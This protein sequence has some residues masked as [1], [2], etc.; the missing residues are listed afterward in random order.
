MLQGIGITQ[1]IAIGQ[2]VRITAG[3]DAV[4]LK[5]PQ[6]E[7]LISP[8]EERAKLLA[9][10][11][12]SRR[13]IQEI[14]ANTTGGNTEII[15]TQMDYFDDPAFN[16][17]SFTLIETEGLSAIQAIE[18][19]TRELYETFQSFDDDPYMQGR[20]ADIADAGNRILNNLLGKATDITK[21]IPPDSILAAR[22]LSPSQTA[23]LDLKNVLGF[24]TEQG[25]KTCHTAIMARSM[26]IA[27]VVGCPGIMEAT[28]DGDTI[29]VDARN[30]TVLLRPDIAEREKYAA[31]QTEIESGENLLELI[32]ESRVM[33]RDNREII[34]AANI[35]NPAEAETAKQRGA[36]G[37]G[38]FRTEFLFMSRD[39]MPDEEEQYAAYRRVAEIFGEAPVIIRTLDAG[40]DKELPYLKMPGEENPALGLRAIRLCLQN[41]ELFETQLSAI[42]RASVY[43]NLKIMFPMIDNPGELRAA[44]EILDHRKAALKARGIPFRENIETGMMIE[45]P[46]AAL[47]AETFAKEADFFSIGTNDL[48]QYTLAVDRGNP[49]VADL[50][51]SMHPAVMLLIKNTIEA[52]HRAGILCCMCGELASDLNALPI[53]AD[54]GLDEF[55]VGT[56]S[57]G[58]IKQALLHHFKA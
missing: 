54:Y 31:Q 9:A 26:G 12:A 33:D 43:G 21:A 35:G 55:S 52:A 40:G 5:E 41:R 36:G 20:A 50:Y 17:D 57:V 23:Q 24:V 53:L 1:R 19:Q 2:V 14:L 48:T 30:G 10:L 4:P 44:K 16:D 27:A 38:L 56:G 28:R 3:A 47:M 39:A 25:S 34:V 58:Q 51:D 46:A 22:D 13:Q 32:E 18:R 45:T 42:L 15:T 7:G 8:A 29:I 37:I 49:G 11:D 6:T